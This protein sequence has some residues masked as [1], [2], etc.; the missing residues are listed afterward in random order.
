MLSHIPASSAALLK[1]TNEIAAGDAEGFITDA[2]SIILLSQYKGGNF[3]E[4]LQKMSTWEVLQGGRMYTVEDILN[5][6]DGVRAELLDGEMFMMATPS[7]AHQ[8]I[9]AWLTLEVGLHIRIRKGK[10]RVIPAPFAVFLMN[11][12]KNYVEP[13]LLV[14]CE[15]NKERLQKDGCHGA[16]DLAVEIVSPSSKTMDYVRKLQAYRTAG[17]QEYWIIDYEKEQVQVYRLQSEVNVPQPEEYSFADCAVSKVVE[18]L[19]LD[20]AEL[21]K[22]LE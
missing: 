12:D 2:N 18:G 13:D 22:Y 6:P 7:I 15:K 1:I 3:M 8:E 16:P 11:D 5:L 20:F 17:V 21:R 10:C 14:V 19:T 4:A 9:L